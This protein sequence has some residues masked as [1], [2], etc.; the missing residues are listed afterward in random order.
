MAETADEVDGQ[1][2]N[3]RIVEKR[4]PGVNCDQPAEFSVKRRHIRNLVGHADAKRHVDKFH[5]T[6]VGR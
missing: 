2:Q 5:I 1:R 6:D 3:E 4:E